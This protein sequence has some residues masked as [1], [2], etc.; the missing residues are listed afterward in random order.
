MGR[1]TVGFMAITSI[2]PLSVSLL[3][4]NADLLMTRDIIQLVIGLV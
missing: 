2:N 1:R 4:W 3:H